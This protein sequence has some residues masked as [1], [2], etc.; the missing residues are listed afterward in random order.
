[1]QKR[2]FKNR[3]EWRAWLVE[4]HDKVQELWLVFYKVKS[5]KESIKYNEAV[6]EALCF[7]WIDSTLRRIDDEKHMQ[8][9]TPRKPKG[10]WAQSNKRRVAKLIKSGLMT[11][12]G[13]AVIDAAK[14]NGAWNSLDSVE[15]N[16]QVP[17]ELEVALKKDREAKRRFDALAMSHKK[18]FVWWIVSAKRQ[19]TRDRRVNETIKRLLAQ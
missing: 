7:G 5:G 13:Q 11:A 17:Q 14:A 4:N 2:L 3:A 15:V 1:M 8:R 12:A 19:D 16:F 9:Y 10:I 18:Q 6:E